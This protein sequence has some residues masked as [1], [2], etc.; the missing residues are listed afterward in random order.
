MDVDDKAAE[1]PAA[2]A[3]PT[4]RQEPKPEPRIEKPK[5]QVKK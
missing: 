1:L 3:M 5:E 2:P 4:P